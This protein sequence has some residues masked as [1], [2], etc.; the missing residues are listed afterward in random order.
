MEIL[1]GKCQVRVFANPEINCPISNDKLQLIDLPLLSRDVK[2]RIAQFLGSLP[3]AIVPFK[4][5]SKENN[6]AVSQVERMMRRDALD[7]ISRDYRLDGLGTQITPQVILDFFTPIPSNFDRE[8]P[9]YNTVTA[10]ARFCKSNGISLG[11]V[12]SWGTERCFTRDKYLIFEMDDQLWVLTFNINGQPATASMVRGFY[13][14]YGRPRYPQEEQFSPF[15]P[16]ERKKVQ[17]A[18][19]KLEAKLA[20]EPEK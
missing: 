9:Y 17:E 5:T 10:A 15:R 18:L 14:R 2:G 8:F 6:L 1:D 7:Q 16:Q 11:R 3:E 19:Q 4:A 12:E 20:K 13:T